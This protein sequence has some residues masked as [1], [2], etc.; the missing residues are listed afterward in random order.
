MS[1]ERLQGTHLLR[2]AH[3]AAMGCMSGPGARLDNT[4]ARLCYRRFEPIN[5]GGLVRDDHARG[6]SAETHRMSVVVW[7]VWLGGFVGSRAS[8]LRDSAGLLP[9]FRQVTGLHP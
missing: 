1:N 3:V 9:G 7:A 2:I 5:N 4:E 8:Q 6:L